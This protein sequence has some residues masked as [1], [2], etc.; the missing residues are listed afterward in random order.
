ME[1]AM[2]KLILKLIKKNFNLIFLRNPN[3]SATY[4]EYD[5][6]STTC[7]INSYFYSN[8]L[9]IQGIVEG[10]WLTVL[11]IQNLHLFLFV[12]F[13]HPRTN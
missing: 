4:P 1:N 2:F 6:Y 13:Q 11:K 7:P 5:F 12:R 10:T 8:F 3:S 9:A